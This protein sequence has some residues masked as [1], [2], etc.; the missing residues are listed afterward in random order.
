M[1]AMTI[2]LLLMA[3]CLAPA[4]QESNVASQKQENSSAPA[5]RKAEP[6]LAPLAGDRSEPLFADSINERA[7]QASL[8]RLRSKNLSEDDIE[9]RVW[10][11]FGKK[12]LEGFV[13][14]RIDGQWR[15]VFLESMN[16]TNKPPY[17][18]ELSPKPGWE[19]LWRQLVDA[20]LLTLPD[21]SQLKDEVRVKDGTSYVVEVK[22]GGV[23][24]T[25]GYM[26]PSCQKWKEA[27]RM[28][29]IA[30]LLYKGFGLKR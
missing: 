10:V 1:N 16:F 15:G 4:M 3:Y 26:N 17:R 6:Q 20:R 7:K 23:Y 30:D 9:F 22:Q 25:Y 8:P 21:S 19:K 27:K 24:R 18:R 29:R 5:S 2:L 11:G 12:P 13:I 28:L 14:S